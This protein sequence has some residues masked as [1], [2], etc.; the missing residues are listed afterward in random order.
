LVDDLDVTLRFLEDIAGAGPVARF[1]STG[2]MAAAG[3]GWPAEHGA[4]RGAMVGQRQGLL[5]LVEIPAG[6]RDTLR[7][8]VA[9]LSFANRDIEA[10]TADAKAAGFAVEGPYSLV[11]V[12]ETVSTISRIAA[13][14]VPF[15]L[16]RFGSPSSQ[17]EK[18]G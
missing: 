18:A 4:T 3:L 15:E 9:G 11:G 6:L 2:E 8:G 12:D 1:E 17:T 16:I 13:G 7:P 5:E 14:G 10:K